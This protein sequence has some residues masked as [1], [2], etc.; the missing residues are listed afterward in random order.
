[1]SHA[2]VVQLSGRWTLTPEFVSSNPAGMKYLFFLDLHDFLR[3]NIYGEKH[4]KSRNTPKASLSKIIT[5][6]STLT[7]LVC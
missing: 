7:F 2:R 1:M 4:A 5:R 3:S 6:T